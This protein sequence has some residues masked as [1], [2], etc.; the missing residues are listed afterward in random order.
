MIPHHQGAV[1]MAK[2]LAFGM[3]PEIEKL[4]EAVIRARETEIAAMR[5]WLQ[6]NVQ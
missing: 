1:E 5:A 6:R 4:T 3:E 2:V